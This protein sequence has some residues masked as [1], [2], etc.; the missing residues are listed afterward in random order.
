MRLLSISSILIV[1]VDVAHGWPSLLKWRSSSSTSPSTRDDWPTTVTK[2]FTAITQYLSG[3]GGDTPERLGSVLK[4]LG[5]ELGEDMHASRT[6]PVGMSVAVSKVLLEF[7][8]S[9]VITKI[10]SPRFRRVLN[11]RLER[12]AEKLK[13]NGACMVLPRSGRP[14]TCNDEHFSQSVY[15]DLVLI[16]ADASAV[17]NAISGKNQAKN[18]LESAALLRDIMSKRPLPGVTSVDEFGPFT[19]R[20]WARRDEFTIEPSSV[21]NGLT[22]FHRH[23]PDMAS[24]SVYPPEFAVAA[25]SYE[26]S[27][28]R[29]INILGFLRTVKKQEWN[30]PAFRNLID[31]LTTA[32]E[33]SDVMKV[34]KLTVST[35]AAAAVLKLPGDIFTDLVEQGL[36]RQPTS[37][38][39]IA[40]RRGQALLSK[41][42]RRGTPLDPMLLLSSLSQS[43]E[44]GIG[45]RQDRIEALGALV[46]AAVNLVVRNEGAEVELAIQWSRIAMGALNEI[47]E[48]PSGTVLQSLRAA[49]AVAI[50]VVPIN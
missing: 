50:S 36:V 33:A 45:Y 19:T 41:H 47:F 39:L 13:N 10:S 49:L 42:R 40:R 30:Q 44:A 37:A 16:G 3:R 32:H 1:L 24:S 46:L 20:V 28:L 38:E 7:F 6:V 12:L 34:E 43:M 22:A 9:S 21:V 4:Q 11:S 18:V 5:Y 17:V 23:R 35:E 27:P 8:E 2:R 25:L 31:A 26:E 29:V 48:D 15:V 14:A